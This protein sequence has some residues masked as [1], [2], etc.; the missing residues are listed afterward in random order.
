MPESRQSL[1]LY[2]RL[3]EHVQLVGGGWPSLSLSFSVRFLNSAAAF[4]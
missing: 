3:D 4:R 1:R 2:R